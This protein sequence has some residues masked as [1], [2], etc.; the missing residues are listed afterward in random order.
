[1]GRPHWTQYA[2]IPLCLPEQLCASGEY[3]GGGLTSPRD[4][5]KSGA[6]VPHCRSRAALPAFASM[7]ATAATWRGSPEW[8]AQS[9]ATSAPE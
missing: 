5:W 8:L 9:S 7:S 2:S 3:G 6:C 1:M 4:S